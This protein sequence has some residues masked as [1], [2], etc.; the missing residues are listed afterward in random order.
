MDASE[1]HAKRLNAKEVLTPKNGECI[2]F[3]IADGTVKLSGGDQI[4]RT[5]TLIQ[6]SPD[7]GEQQGKLPGETD[8]SPAQDSSLVKQE[9]FFGLFQEISFTAITWNPESNCTG[10]EKNHFQIY[11]RYQNYRYI[12]GRIVGEKHRRMIGTLMEIENCQ[13]R[14]QVSHDSPYWTTNHG[15]GIHGP[16]E[17]LTK[18]TTSRPDYLW[19]EIWKDTSEAAQRKEKQKW[20]KKRSS[21]M[22]EG[23]EGFTSL[24]QQMRSSKKLK[25][26][27]PMPAAMP[28]K[29]RGGKYRKPVALL[30]SKDKIRMHR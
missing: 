25:L 18:Q 1:I 30:F 27:V 6:D 21:T 28:C 26:E 5:S 13:I 11:R 29:T 19:P 22:Q 9:M 24:I 15:M 10:R 23:C 8:G 14:G 12:I 20:S 2:K 3:P 16:G 7:R 17:R 4:L